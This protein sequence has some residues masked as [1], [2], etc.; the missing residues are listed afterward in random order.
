MRDAPEK[1]FLAHRL[2]STIGL[3]G[4]GIRFTVQF[5]LFAGSIIGLGGDAQIARLEVGYL[6]PSLSLSRTPLSLSHQCH[7]TGHA[8][9]R[10]ARVFPADR[11]AGRSAVRTDRQDYH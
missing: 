3:G 10:G 1:F 2:L 4:F 8:K 11:D 7:H 6:P 9:G 5:N